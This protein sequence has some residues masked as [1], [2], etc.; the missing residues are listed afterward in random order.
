MT[1]KVDKPRIVRVRLSAN[2]CYYTG[3]PGDQLGTCTLHEMIDPK[4]GKIL[5]SSFSNNTED[6]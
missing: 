3:V 4:S 6:S 1:N 5:N 2:A